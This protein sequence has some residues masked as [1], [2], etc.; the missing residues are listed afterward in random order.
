MEREKPEYNTE[1]HLS[2]ADARIGE[3]VVIAGISPDYEMRARLT[4]LGFCRGE[5]VRCVM[6]S[7]LRD[8][9][10]YLIRGALIALRGSDAA[11]I[12]VTK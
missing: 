1:K 6:E 2:L 8:P 9:R 5:R 7:P 11:K 3:E 10:A 4:E 12:A